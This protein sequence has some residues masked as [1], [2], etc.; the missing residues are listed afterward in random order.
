MV[1]IDVEQQGGRELL[2]AVW[3]RLINPRI[4][5]LKLPDMLSQ[6]QRRAQGRSGCS[7]LDVHRTSR[8]VERAG[9]AETILKEAHLASYPLVILY[10][11]SQQ[12]RSATVEPFQTGN[13]RI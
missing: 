7:C 3:S 10:L 1:F 11:G 4:P 8:P 2:C 9:S 13:L 5:A 12:T 6:A